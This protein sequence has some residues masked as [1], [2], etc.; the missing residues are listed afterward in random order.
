MKARLEWFATVKCP[1]AVAIAHTTRPAPSRYHVARA[2][3]RRQPGA[4]PISCG[5]V[6]QR[7]PSRRVDRNS[8]CMPA[9]PARSPRTG[10]HIPA[11]PHCAA[12]TRPPT[13]RARDRSGRENGGRTHLLVVGHVIQ[14]RRCAATP[15]ARARPAAA[16]TRRCTSNRKRYPIANTTPAPPDPERLIVLAPRRATC[17][18]R[19]RR[20]ATSTP[21]R[22]SLSIVMPTP[23][24]RGPSGRARRVADTPRPAIQGPASAL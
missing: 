9:R 1:R 15:R 19:T 3:P 5:Y 24:M 8:T 14:P 22:R 6:A 16:R 23:R 20:T 7:P 18:Y 2:H 10:P 13:A 21:S 4:L 17:P 11:A 12:I